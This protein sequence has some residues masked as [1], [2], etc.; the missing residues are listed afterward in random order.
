MKPSGKSVVDMM[1]GLKGTSYDEIDCQAA[2]ERAVYLSGGRMSYSGS[3]AMARNLEWLG[4]LDNALAYFGGTLPIGAGLFINEEVSGRTPAKYRGDGLGDFS[5]V[6]LYAGKNALWDT[7]KKG[8]Y[9]ACDAIHSSSSMGRV[10]GTTLKNGWTHVGLFKEIDYGMNIESGVELSPKAEEYL[11]GSQNEPDAIVTNNEGEA[12]QQ[13]SYRYVTVVSANGKP[14]RIREKP[15]KGS[16]TKYSVPVGTRLM[17]IREKNG[18][19]QVMYNGKA[20]WIMK[21]FTVLEE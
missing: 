9:R 8:D 14:V 19:Y 21:E 15:Q 18:F 7:D 2:I 1:I 12:I 17:A 20:R 4:T 16:I 13:V 10:A 11:N 5:H 3:N 6:G